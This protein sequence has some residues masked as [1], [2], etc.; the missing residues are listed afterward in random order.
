MRK[1]GKG[2]A[3]EDKLAI[4][5]AIKEMEE[6][7]FA[8]RRTRQLQKEAEKTQQVTKSRIFAGRKDS[9]RPGGQA[10]KVSHKESVLGSALAS[11]KSAHHLADFRP[12][13]SQ[14]RNSQKKIIRTTAGSQPRAMNQRPSSQDS[15]NNQ[16]ITKSK[17]RQHSA[18]GLQ[19]Q[20][21]DLSL[22][23][24]QDP[25]R[26]GARIISGG[27]SILQGQSRT[28]GATQLK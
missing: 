8:R 6:K 17:Q 18:G 7:L 3:T 19:D 15:T 11:S 25:D 1:Q 5:Q 28:F 21:T 10:V 13:A 2:S 26:Q 12:K 4:G 22:S 23:N 27:N 14:G 20:H 16:A 9:N 24:Q